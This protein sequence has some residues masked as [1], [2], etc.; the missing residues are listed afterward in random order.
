MLDPKAPTLNT[1]RYPELVAQLKALVQTYRS[2]YTVVRSERQALIHADMPNLAGLNAA[3]IK[4]IQSIKKAEDSWAQIA[5]DMRGASAVDNKTPR[6]VFLALQLEGS[7][8]AYLLRLRKV[9]NLLVERT[10]EMN[11]QNATLIESALAHVNGAM[12]AITKDMGKES[13]YQ[14]KGKKKDPTDKLS[15]R[16]MSKEV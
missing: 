6:L 2:L 12:S 9:L 10:H 7:E 4:L 14:N 8:R 15:G 16:L 5:E 13:T 11:K 1:T 3:K